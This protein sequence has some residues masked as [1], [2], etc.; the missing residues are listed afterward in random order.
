MVIDSRRMESARQTTDAEARMC[1]DAHASGTF[2]FF[3][4]MRAACIERTKEKSASMAWM[5]LFE[6]SRR[7]VA[8]RKTLQ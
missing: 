8:Q 6:S 1:R 7:A 4:G 3:T 5:R 2:R